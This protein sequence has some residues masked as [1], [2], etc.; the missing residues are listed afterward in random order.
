MTRHLK[1]AAAVAL[2]LGLAP[3]AYGDIQQKSGNP[4]F[5]EA[6]ELVIKN[7]YDPSA[8]GRF[9]ETVH[10]TI[11]GLPPSF[12]ADNYPEAYGPAIAK[13]VASLGVS[14]TGHFVPG[15]VDYYELADIFRFN[16]RDQL[17]RLFPPEG[18]VTYPG[19]GIASKPIGG[20]RFVTDVYDGAPADRAGIM[21]GDEILSLDGAPFEEVASFRGKV[22]ETAQLVVRREA[23]GEPLTFGVRVAELQPS[24]TL[25]ESISE[26]VDMVEEEGR[27]IGYLRIWFFADDEVEDAIEQALSRPAQG[28]RRAGRRPSRPLGRRPAGRG[29]DLPRRHPLLPLHQPQRPGPGLQRPLAQA[30]GRYHRRGYP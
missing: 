25:V 28:R 29:R 30:V 20:K 24:D 5:D 14:H 23:A 27:K 8:I 12:A 21:V 26:S 18:K 7:F 6:V 2:F 9:K 16:Y 3:A 15:Q 22:G 10:E 17:R 11:K 4:V 13:I 19:I 1:Y